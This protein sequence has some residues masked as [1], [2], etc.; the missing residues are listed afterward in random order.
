M[1]FTKLE[2]LTLYTVAFMENDAV[3]KDYINITAK[4]EK[5][6]RIILHYTSYIIL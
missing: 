3:K 1:C 4:T 5:Y 2:I 6:A